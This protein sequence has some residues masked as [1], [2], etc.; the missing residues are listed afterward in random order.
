KYCFDCYTV[1]KVTKAADIPLNKLALNFQGKDNKKVLKNYDFS[2]L[3]TETYTVDVPVYESCT[4]THSVMNNATGENESVEY[5]DQCLVRTDQV[6]K[7]REVYK[8]VSLSTMKNAYNNADVGDSYYIKVSGKLKNGDAVDNI[9]TLNDYV[10]DEYAWWNASF[11]H[12]MQINCSKVSDGV[13]VIINGSGGFSIS[14]N[15]QF[16]WTVCQGTNLSVYYNNYTDYVVANNSGQVPFEVERG[17]GTSYNPASVW[18][19]YVGVYHFGAG[20]TSS[21]TKDSLEGWNGGV[22]GPDYGNS[23]GKADGAYDFE[24]DNVD[25][26]TLKNDAG[27]SSAINTFC[28]WVKPETCLNNADRCV[29]WGGDDSRTYWWFRLGQDQKPDLTYKSSGTNGQVIA[30]NA[31]VSGQWLYICA[32]YDSSDTGNEMKVYV[33]GSFDAQDSEDGS[34]ND[35][36]SKNRVGSHQGTAQFMD[37]IIDELTLHSTVRTESIINQT[38]HNFIGTTGFGTLLSE[39]SQGSSIANETEG[40]AAIVQ[41]IN[42]SALSSYSVYSDRQVYI[43]LNNGSQYKGTFDKFLVS[44]SKRWAFNYDQNTSSSFPVFYNIAPSFYIWQ[45]FALTYNEIKGNVTAFVNS[46]YQ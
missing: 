22:S 37:G 29:I 15:K 3:K 12:R 42:N 9:L 7:Q 25:N 33:N 10:Y 20:S 5:Q 23:A 39:E 31:V 16:V 44:G 34:L 21:F 36:E 38:Y 40:R 14:G 18:T 30:T 41:G 1:Y 11:N 2:Y 6:E 4:K 24:Q 8:P 28:A 27:F 26:L 46:T 35:K 43:R 13:P 19:G 32:M 17:N 45:K